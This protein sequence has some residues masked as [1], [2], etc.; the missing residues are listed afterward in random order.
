MGGGGL[1]WGEQG[2]GCLHEGR[3]RRLA[4]ALREARPAEGWKWRVAEPHTAACAHL[5][6]S[7]VA[8]TVP[9]LSRP[10]RSESSLARPAGNSL[11][12]GKD[13][14]RQ[15]ARDRK[16]IRPGANSHPAADHPRPPAPPLEQPR[17]AE[18]QGAGCR[19]RRGPGPGESHD[20]PKP[21]APSPGP[22]RPGGLPHSSTR[23]QPRGAPAPSGGRPSPRARECRLLPTSPILHRQPPASVLLTPASPKRVRRQQSKVPLLRS[24]FDPLGGEGRTLGPPPQTTEASSPWP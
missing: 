21:P 7:P 13:E 11:Q 14:G 5:S 20:L 16:K 9:V 4:S 2:W 19:G 12:K 3:G 24:S 6:P 22:P 18:L 23:A 10:E 1:H 15:G 8:N 17:R